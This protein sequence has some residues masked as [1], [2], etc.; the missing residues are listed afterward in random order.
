MGVANVGVR[1]EVRGKVF[2]TE[3][4]HRQLSQFAMAL[5]FLLGFYITNQTTRSCLLF[6]FSSFLFLVFRS[7][8]SSEE[9]VS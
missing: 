6:W 8:L 1:G 7:Q 9:M 4:L 2:F 3:I 5:N